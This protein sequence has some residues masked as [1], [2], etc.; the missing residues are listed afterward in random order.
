MKRPWKGAV[1]VTP[2]E[3]KVLVVDPEQ[4]DLLKAR[5]PP[6]AQHPR[7]LLTLLEGVALWQ[8]Q[9]LRVV[10]SATSA[11]DGRPCWSGSGLFGDE[12]WPVESQLVRYEV[13]DRA[14]QRRAL[15]GLGDFRSLRVAPRG[16]EL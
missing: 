16:G 7:A 10:V 9:P 13:A 12:L 1:R 6:V 4:G 3:V 11:G 15:V 14:L 2:R 8:G 5:L